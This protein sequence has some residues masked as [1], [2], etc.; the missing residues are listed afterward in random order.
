MSTLHGG[1]L[2]RVEYIKEYFVQAQLQWQRDQRQLPFKV[3]W[4]FGKYDSE[5]GMAYM[6]EREEMH[7]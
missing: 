5:D 4:V 7:L 6:G 3:L 1:F 2:D